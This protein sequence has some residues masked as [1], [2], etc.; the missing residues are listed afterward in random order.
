VTSLAKR[1]LTGL[2]QFLLVLG[3]LLLLPAWSLHYWEAW[4]Y[5]A[6]FSGCTLAITIQ[7]LRRDPALVARRL[8]AGPGAE[9][10]K[11][12]KIIQALASVLVVVLFVVPGLDRRFGWS[13]SIG[14]AWEIGADVLVAVGFLVMFL[15]FRENTHA[16]SIIAVEADQ[17]VVSSGV[18]ALVRHPLY[19]GGLLS[20]L[21]TPI[22]L[23]SVIAV[24]PAVALSVVI[25]VRLLAEE[26]FLV[27]HLAGY[28]AYC[29][30]VR[31][32]LVP[33]V[34]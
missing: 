2:I 21:A 12:Q 1:A 5:W 10:E 24:I 26:R 29:Q 4:L 18:Y 31:F 22:A 25:G 15:A 16:A 33:G 9:Q 8:H 7:L 28:R 34:W 14:A 6:V 30:I 19:T 20:F 11:T 23:G 17:R 13:P 3:L 32:R 27:E